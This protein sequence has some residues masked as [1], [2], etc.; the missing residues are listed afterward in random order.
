MSGSDTTDLQSPASPGRWSRVRWVL[1]G[2][3]IAGVLGLELSPRAAAIVPGM[4]RIDMFTDYPLLEDK[5]AGFIRLEPNY[6]GRVWGRPFRT[7]SYGF[8]SPPIS[9]TPEP[10]ELRIVLLG[11]CI[12]LGVHDLS[13][14]GYGFGSTTLQARLQAR[15]PD[16][17]IRVI[18][19]GVPGSFE[20][21]NL[22]HYDSIIKDL[23]PDLVI[24][25]SG[26]VQIFDPA[27]MLEEYVGRR[28]ASTEP[29]DNTRGWGPREYLYDVF[30]RSLLISH[31]YT[32]RRNQGMLF[33]RYFYR[34]A[35]AV[36]TGEAGQPELVTRYI[37]E[38]VN[39][40]AEYYRQDVA[41]LYAALSSDL[42]VIAYTFPHPL[43]DADFDSVSDAGRRYLSSV[44]LMQGL[45]DAANGAERWALARYT[46]D[47]IEGINRM[48]AGAHGVR[49]LDLMAYPELRD[50]KDYDEYEYFL[51][52][53]R[54]SIKRAKV[55]ADY[56]LD[57][58]TFSQNG[59]S[60]QI[61]E[62]GGE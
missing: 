43:P 7:D 5:D 45:P 54:G 15:Y 4:R 48:E 50:I 37:A 58:Y 10:N 14:D 40:S 61:T 53:S 17:K 49:Y 23:N 29:A 19:A 51:P 31:F 41:D 13:E 9:E 11:T 26:S 46:Y 34:R 21:Q 33:R 25:E 47:L 32:F 59:S 6:S 30:N 57:N 42:A 44:E 16:L 38:V 8:R 28:P 36:D 22:L 35:E 1:V 18:N 12:T 55:L 24:L 62:A 39:P 2:L 56:I 3:L 27:G 20:L 60:V 52:H